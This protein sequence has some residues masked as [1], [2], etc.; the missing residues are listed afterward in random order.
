MN[1]DRSRKGRIKIEIKLNRMEIF[2]FLTYHLSV[3][4]EMPTTRDNTL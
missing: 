1:V 4:P 3:E 2:A